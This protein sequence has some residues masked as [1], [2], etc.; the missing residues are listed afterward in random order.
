VLAGYLKKDVSTLFYN[1]RPSK[2][3]FPVEQWQATGLDNLKLISAPL[4]VTSGA[5]IEVKN[6]VVA[7]LKLLMHIVLNREFMNSHLS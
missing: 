6:K 2:V 5:T 3:S 7:G 1:C 4:T